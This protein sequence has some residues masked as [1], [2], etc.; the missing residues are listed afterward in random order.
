VGANT[1]VVLR[2]DAAPF[3]V[4]I[5]GPPKAAAPVPA[6]GPAAPASAP[7]AAAPQ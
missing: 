7:P 3:N 5:E 1:R 2:T 4:L 6:P